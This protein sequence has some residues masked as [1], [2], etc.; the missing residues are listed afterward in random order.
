[1]VKKFLILILV[2]LS[3]GIN[4]GFTGRISPDKVF[5]NEISIKDKDPE[6]KLVSLPVLPAGPVINIVRLVIEQITSR[7]NVSLLFTL[8]AFVLFIIRL[9]KSLQFKILLKFSR[10]RHLLLSVMRV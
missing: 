3:A 1:M 2:F 6:T 7:I 10:P 4:P 9:L 5:I 8:A